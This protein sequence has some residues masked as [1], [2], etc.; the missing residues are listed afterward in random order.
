MEPLA[1][2]FLGTADV[3][4][5]AACLEVGE[6][7]VPEGANRSVVPVPGTV[8]SPR[9][10]G[11]IPGEGAALLFPLQPP[12]V[13]DPG[14]RVAEQ[15]EDPEGIA[16]PPVALVAVEHDGGLRCDPDPGK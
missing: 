10:C 3:H 13:H 15:L 7:V 8:D 14:V 16:G 11:H 12:A 5:G 2:E 4:Q 9:I 1:G 6:D